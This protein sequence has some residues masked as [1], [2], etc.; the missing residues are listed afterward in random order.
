MYKLIIAVF[1]ALATQTVSAQT[2]L[3]PGDTCSSIAGPS[4]VPCHPEHL[5]C[6]VALD[7]SVCYDGP[8]CPSSFLEEGELCS[9]IA[10]P[11]PNPCWPGTTCCNLGP[12]RSVCMAD[13]NA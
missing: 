1:A 8:E 2:Y 4:S 9:G 3:E 13:C 7:Y 10:G 12:D 11:S 5:C 6:Q